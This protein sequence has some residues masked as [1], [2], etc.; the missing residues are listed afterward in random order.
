MP[1]DLL[2][3]V[4]GPSPYSWWWLVLGLVVVAAVIA[5]CAGVLVWTLPA[6]RLRQMPLIGPVHALM[7][8]RRFAH[9]IRTAIEGYRSGELSAP[10]AATVM[11][12]TLRSFLALVTGSRAQY[13]HVGDMAAGNLA[14][15]AQ[16]FAAL[17]D[18]Q[19]NIASA[20]DLDAV[21]DEAEELITSWT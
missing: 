5:W 1:G 6:E 17:N 20:V 11:R 18:I 10:E 4:C 8:R 19:F 15:A 9:T 21:A 13:M 7:I 3:Y 14:P 2:R 16:V 12:G